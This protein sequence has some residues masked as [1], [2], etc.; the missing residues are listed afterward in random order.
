M[1]V[2]FEYFVI[3]EGTK[4]SIII[5]MISYCRDNLDGWL[6]LGY[7]KVRDKEKMCR[8]KQSPMTIPQEQK[9]ELG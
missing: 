8:R 6:F 4:T 7:M 2:N 1:E 3:K 5:V 9:V